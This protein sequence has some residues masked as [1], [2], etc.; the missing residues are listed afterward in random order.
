V[1]F[2][3]G[4]HFCLGANFARIQL[5]CILRE[6]FSRLPDIHVVKPPRRQRSN[7]IQGITE[8]QV[9]FTPEA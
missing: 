5:R 4:E 9:E 3:I 6:V 8:M 1:S 7:L 2:G